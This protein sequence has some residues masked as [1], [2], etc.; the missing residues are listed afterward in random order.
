MHTY[1]I[2]PSSASN[3][4]PFLGFLAEKE[5]KNIEYKWLQHYKIS[6]KLQIIKT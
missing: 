2:Q 1:L 6:D 3:L 4:R 5:K